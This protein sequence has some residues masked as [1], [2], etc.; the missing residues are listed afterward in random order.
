M[1]NHI[2]IL[3]LLVIL[4]CNCSHDLETD[5]EHGHDGEHE[6]EVLNSLAYTNYSDKSELFVEFKP[7]VVGEESKITVHLT[8]LGEY[9]KPLL[10]GKIKVKLTENGETEV[11]SPSSPGIFRPTIKPIKAGSNFQLTFEV[12]TKEFKDIFTIDNITVYPDVQSALNNQSKDFESNDISYLKEQAWKVEF[13]NEEVQK[14]PFFYTIKTTGQLLTPPGE[15]VTISA[16]S[17]GIVSYNGNYI[18]GMNVYKG[19]NLFNISGNNLNEENINTKIFE[20]KS[21]LEKSKL[22]Y[23]RALELNKDKIISDKELLSL[24]NIYE[25]SEE[26]YYSISKNYSGKGIRVFTPI[27]GYLK[28]IN[29][30]QGDYVISGQILAIVS[31]NSRL[32]LKADLSQKF[33]GIL[34]EIR[35]ATFVTPDGRLYDTENLN[36][37][38]IVIGKFTG[39]ENLMLPVNIEID[40]RQ[41]LIPGTFVEVYLKTKRLADAIAIPKTAL[42]EEQGIYYVYIQTGGE[43]FQKREVK[44]GES[45]G[46]NVQILSGIEVGERVVTKGAYHIKLSSLS[47]SLPDHGHEH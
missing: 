34:N 25:I 16:N 28:S 46:I 15:E 6:E 13:A 45:D 40:F 10:E 35:S 30:K 8:L 37:K 14:K 17:N 9:F 21:N 20:A 33:I 44:T 7:F 32:I 1:K 4:N 36:G 3:L 23:E 12:E 19:E 27:S 26:I 43:S 5:H 18:S 42:T 39:K 24:K 2:V 38:S 47:G 22:D 31:Q 41:D 11:N 29:V